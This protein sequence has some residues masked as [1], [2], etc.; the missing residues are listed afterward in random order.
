MSKSLRGI[1]RFVTVILIA[2][3]L[4][5][6]AA[7][8]EPVEQKASGLEGLVGTWKLRGES[9]YGELLHILVVA[10]DGTA[11]YESSGEVA[12]VTNLEIDG[13]KVRFDMT[14]FGGP[15]SY[16]LAFAGSYDDEVL[17][18][19]ILSNG[20]SFAAMKA[21]RR[22]DVSGLIGTW[23]LTGSSQFGPMEHELVVAADGTATYASNGEVSTVTNLSIDGNMVRFD[24]T[25]WGGPGSYDV[26]FEGSFD[27]AGLTGDILT[28]GGSFATLTAPRQP[29][30]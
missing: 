2:S 13:N 9:R 21:R 17:T 27:E 15:G 19:D 30:Q 6:G 3:L 22:P 29:R 16:E 10:S 8:Q 11:S 7:A 12:D 24:M 23:K 26:A 28:S 5:I 25:V 14:V 1:L 18:G 20:A 4:P